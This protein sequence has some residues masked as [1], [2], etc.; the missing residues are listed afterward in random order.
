MLGS[1]VFDWESDNCSIA[2]T[3]FSSVSSDPE[4]NAKGVTYSSRLINYPKS[5]LIDT[6][7]Y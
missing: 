6:S 3:A 5:L 1:Y 4:E 2:F 7:P